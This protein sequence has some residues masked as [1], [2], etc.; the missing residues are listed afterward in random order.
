[1][2][3]NFMISCAA[4]YVTGSKKTGLIAHV[5]EFDFSP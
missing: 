2:V 4:V 5:S 1:M 3:E